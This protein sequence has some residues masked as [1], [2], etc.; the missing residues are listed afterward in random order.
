[1]HRTRT[2]TLTLATAMMV[3]ALSSATAQGRCPEGRAANGACAKPGLVQVARKS[4]VVDTQP[5]LSFT[6][7]PVLPS[8]DYE[9][10][11]LPAFM[12]IFRLF[13]PPQ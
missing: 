9:Y 7:P 12:E 2:V 8:E 3:G 4:T 11:P 10:R 5:K 13:P 1:M 6:A